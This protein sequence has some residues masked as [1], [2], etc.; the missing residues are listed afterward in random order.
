MVTPQHAQE[1]R[2]GG[3]ELGLN[4]A[5]REDIVPDAGRL[6]HPFRLG[7][8]GIGPGADRGERH[9]VASVTGSLGH[10]GGDRQQCGGGPRGERPVLGRADAV[11]GSVRDPSR[12][13]GIAPP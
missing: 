2:P 6:D 3:G 13:G 1:V 9:E 5:A 11:P 4:L 12:V 8:H 10:V 7:E